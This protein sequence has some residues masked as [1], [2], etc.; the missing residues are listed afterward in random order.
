MESN[1]RPPEFDR[2]EVARELAD[3]ERAA[4]APYIN[5][6]PTQWWE[7][8][9]IATWAGA[10]VYA[11]GTDRIDGFPQA[12]LIFALVGVELV[13]INWR[14]R[15]HGAMPW[16]GKGNPPPEIAKLWRHYYLGV[17]AFA[18]MIAVVWILG[19]HV[20]A[21]VFVFFLTL[22]SLTWYETRYGA[23]ATRVR[24]RLG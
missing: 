5:Y 22:V 2:Q 24:E 8:V 9:L 13:W 1:D 20:A 19:N 16:P 10:L 14:S 15:S 3:A 23:A 12:L 17:A 11:V 18:A 4:A 7:I 21:A 6:P